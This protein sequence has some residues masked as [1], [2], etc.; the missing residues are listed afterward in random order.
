M[1]NTAVL[2]YLQHRT[3]DTWGQWGY[4]TLFQLQEII[5][6]TPQ[7]THH[8]P[9]TIF[10][11]NERK[12]IISV[13]WRNLETDICFLTS[14][15]RKAVWRSCPLCPQKHVHQVRHKCQRTICSAKSPTRNM[16]VNKEMEKIQLEQNNQTPTHI[17]QY[18]SRTKQNIKVSEEYSIFKKTLI[19]VWKTTEFKII[20]R[21]HTTSQNVLQ[22]P[23]Q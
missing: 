1:E 13:C 6:L 17:H 22:I 2:G 7:W 10:F 19:T 14:S 8:Y 20:S 11:W 23:N 4:S 21:S 16:T 12:R 18:M 15:F 5:P 9:F 3:S